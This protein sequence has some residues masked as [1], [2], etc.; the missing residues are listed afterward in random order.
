LRGKKKGKKWIKRLNQGRSRG[1]KKTKGIKI[2][3]HGRGKG[4][5]V[6]TVLGK[7]GTYFA[8]FCKGGRGKKRGV[9][10]VT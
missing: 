5:L 7:R 8:F 2:F 10:P 6:V 9:T 4:G 1:K 3:L